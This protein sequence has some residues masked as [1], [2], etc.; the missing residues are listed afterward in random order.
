M[1]SCRRKGSSLSDRVAIH[2]SVRV[3]SP[4]KSVKSNLLLC[5]E[6]GRVVPS[7][8]DRIFLQRLVRRQ[9]ARHGGSGASLNE[10]GTETVSVGRDLCDKCLA[11]SR[12]IGRI[13]G[14]LRLALRD[15]LHDVVRVVQRLNGVA[16]ECEDSAIR[17]LLNRGCISVISVNQSEGAKPI[18]IGCISNS[19]DSA[20]NIRTA[21]DR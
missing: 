21:A 14:N 4:D 7:G 16:F 5:E 18:E 15:S 17:E 3:V 12:Q 10:T 9:I 1:P 19:R 13:S 11:R 20:V 8:I 6:P 2:Q